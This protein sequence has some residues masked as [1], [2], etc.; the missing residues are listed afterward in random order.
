[1]EYFEG[2]SEEHGNFSFH[3]ALSE[4]EQEDSWDSLTGLIHEVVGREYLDDHPAPA[5]V[6]YYLCGPPPMVRACL[7]MLSDFSVPE[8]HIYYDEF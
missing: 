8:D 4:P 5:G 3:S 2:L 1:L 7:E 6:D